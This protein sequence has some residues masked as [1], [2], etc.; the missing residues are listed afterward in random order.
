MHSQSRSA[1]GVCGVGVTRR[2]AGVWINLQH[3]LKRA[4]RRR[5]GKGSVNVAP[6]PSIA[7]DSAV[8]FCSSSEVMGLPPRPQSTPEAPKMA[9]KYWAGSFLIHKSKIKK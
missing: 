3:V 7:Y 5:G 2:G 9:E 1:V 8:P 4:I 6:S